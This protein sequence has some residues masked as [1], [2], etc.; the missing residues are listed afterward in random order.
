MQG[1]IA[2]MSDF[3]Y[4]IYVDTKNDKFIMYNFEWYTHLLCWVDFWTK[5]SSKNILFM[6]YCFELIIVFFCCQLY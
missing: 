4:L 5:F 3:K 2:A 1:N 6:G